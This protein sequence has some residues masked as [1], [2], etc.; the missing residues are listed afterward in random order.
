MNFKRTE[1][2]WLSRTRSIEAAGIARAGGLAS[3]PYGGDGAGQRALA[4]APDVSGEPAKAPHALF[5]RRGC[6]WF[7]GAAGPADPTRPQGAGTPHGPVVFRPAA[8]GPWS[9]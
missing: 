3:C 9:R 8:P 6:G 5:A 4:S 2:G 1:N 7:C